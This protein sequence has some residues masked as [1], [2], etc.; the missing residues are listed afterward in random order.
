MMLSPSRHEVAALFPNEAGKRT[1]ALCFHDGGQLV[2][3]C[4]GDGSIRLIDAVSGTSRKLVRVKKYGVS[5]ATYSHH[6]LSI[7]HG[8]GEGGSQS[9][10]VIRYLSLYDNKYLRVF[11]G[12][13]GRVSCLAMCPSNDTFV[14]CAADGQLALWD[15]GSN[16]GALAKLDA[17]GLAAPRAAY[18]PDALALAVSTGKTV[19]LYD[20]RNYQ[21]GPFGAF[22]V[23]LDEPRLAEPLNGEVRGRLQDKATTWCGLVFSPDGERLLLQTDSGIHLLYDAFDFKLLE[24][25]YD[26][27]AIRDGDPATS[28]DEDAPPPLNVTNAAF[29]PDGSHVVA[30]GRDTVLRVWRLNT[31]SQGRPGL[32]KAHACPVDHVAYSSKYDVLASA[33]STTCLW[34]PPD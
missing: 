26:A 34:L 6:E 18:S 21:N 25:L 24:V 10:N 11:K 27:A 5:C 20:A 8:G 4:A 2:V 23:D 3:S 13:S 14:S 32:L 19:R 29:T 28:A 33:C 16:K 7:L 22:D 17:R 31:T 15:L 30:G 12:H 1:T 9:D